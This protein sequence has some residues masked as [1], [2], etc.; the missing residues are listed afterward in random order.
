M[1]TRRI[2]GAAVK[3]IRELVGMSATDLAKSIGV[4]S[5]T[6]SHLEAGARQL[7][8][9]KMR[10]TAT[11][12]GVPLGAITYPVTAAETPTAGEKAA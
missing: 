7:S 12:L 1:T 9:T 10:D 5:G 3:V 8:P 6:I 11:V 2:N 4:T